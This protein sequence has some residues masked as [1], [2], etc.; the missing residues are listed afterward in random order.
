MIQQRLYED[1]K[2]RLMF[3]I[4]QRDMISMR[5]FL[6]EGDDPNWRMKHNDICLLDYAQE[7]TEAT[8]LLLSY[9]AIPRKK[10]KRY[11]DKQ[12]ED[13]YYDR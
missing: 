12:D 7:W 6:A 1:K 9:G 2:D 8:Q 11:S 4:I 5:K 10:P 3:A 13:A